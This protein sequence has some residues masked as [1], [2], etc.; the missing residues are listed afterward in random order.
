MRILVIGGGG[1]EHALVWKLSKS[2]RV[3]R[4]FCA[5]GNAGIARQAACVPISSTDIPGLLSFAR[6]EQVDLTIVGPEAPLVAGIVDCFED[7]GLRIFG[8]DRKAAQLEGSKVFAKEFMARHRI[9]TAPF[10]VFEESVDAK[11]YIRR[12]GGPLVVKADGLASGKGVVVARDTEE[13]VHAVDWIMEKRPFGE[14]GRRVVVEECLVG[15]EAS[16]MAFVD[17]VAVVPMASAQDHKRV[18]DGDTGPN[19]GGMGAYS[20]APV[21]TEAMT[22]RILEEVLLPTVRGLSKDGTAYRG[23]LYAG[24]MITSEGPKVLEFNCRFGDPE[25]QVIMPRLDSDLVDVMEA[26]V[27]GR[28]SGTPVRWS[29]TPAVCVVLASRGYPEQVEIGQVITGLGETDDKGGVVV[30]HAATEH[31]ASES[32]EDHVISSGGRVLGVTA[33]GRDLR[34][35][36]GNAYRAVDGIHFDGMHFRRDI[37]ARALPSQEAKRR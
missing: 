28:L 4:L 29:P 17:G 14:A 24:L 10:R 6:A 27:S 21:V 12:H 26:V 30:F 9:P 15:E 13:A 25:T 16:C 2:P 3:T 36:V 37:A 20:P 7:A 1:R 22:R 31:R 35:A 23:V 34:E 11:V 19:T 18:G 32:G 33:T 5:P 8:P